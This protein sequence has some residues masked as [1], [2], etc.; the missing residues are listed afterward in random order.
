MTVEGYVPKGDENVGQWNN[1]VSPGYFETLGMRLL[2]GRDFDDRDARV[3]PPP[4]PP[5]DESTRPPEFRVAIVNQ[6]FVKKYFPAG[7]PIGRHIGFGSDPGT[8]T[9]MEIIGVV[10]DAKYTDVRDE[11]QRQVFF[12]Y[13]EQNTPRGFTVYVRTSRDADA[14][15]ATIRQE[16][17]R[18]DANLPIFGTRTLDS[19]IARSLRSER[20]IATMSSAFGVLATLLA[21]VGLY[22]VMAYTVARRTREIGIRM[23]LGARSGDIGWLVTREVLLIVVAGIIVGLPAAW[24]LS[25]FVATQLYG[26][27]PMDPL[28]LGA[29][30]IGLTCVAVLAGLVPSR[31]AAKVNPT[32]ALRYE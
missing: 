13:H 3:S 12:P 22:G 10:T 28:A 16:M 5:G 32:V 29:A 6:Q 4:A 7:N 24:W 17:Q 19:Q 11:T 30:I 18:I 25:R 15:F 14:M 2:A 1:A 8:K 31:R 26:V 21:V 9:P 20:M 23:A 27:K